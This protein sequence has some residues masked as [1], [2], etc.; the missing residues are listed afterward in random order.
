[1]REGGELAACQQRGTERY[2]LAVGN[3][4]LGPSAAFSHRQGA[5]TNMLRWLVRGSVTERNACAVGGER[6]RKQAG[7]KPQEEDE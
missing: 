6:G 7:R 2:T 4:H 3:I 5:T 1:M